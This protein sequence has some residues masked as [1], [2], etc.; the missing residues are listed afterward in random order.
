MNGLV[1]SASLIAAFLGGVLA[2]FAPCCVVTLLPNFVAT[3]VRR[4]VRALPATTLLFSTGLALVLLPIVLGV[5][6]LGHTI[7]RYHAAV[8]TTIGIFLIALGTYILTGKRWSLPLP[9]MSKPSGN[10]ATS[11]FFLGTASGVASSCCAPVVAGV[12]AMSALSGS[13]I[14]ALGLG[15]AYIFGMVF[16]LLLFAIAAVRHGQRSNRPLR[17]VTMFG[18][19]LLW[20]DAVSG[21]MFVLFGAITFFLG[22][23]G[24]GSVTPGPLAVWDRVV[25]RRF[26]D[27]AAALGKTPLVLQAGFLVL[28][29]VLVA[30]PLW[31]TMRAD[32]GGGTA[33][34]RG[35]R[36]TRVRTTTNRERD[37]VCGMVVLVRPDSLSADWDAKTYHFCAAACRERFVERPEE[38]VRPATASS[39]SSR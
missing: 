8:F 19:E 1:Y 26:A 39:A 12:V 28:L 33:G 6:A 14:G 37:P 5:G 24:E 18:R 20:T 17:K 36:G 3:A 4:G 31:R 13:W 38:F 22:I 27:L 10:G 21:S 16:P 34:G 35:A 32:D 29:A 25:T 9:M 7:G 11:T 15:L 30:V 23:S 2:L